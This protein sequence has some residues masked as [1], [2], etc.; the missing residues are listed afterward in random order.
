MGLKTDY[1]SRWANASRLLLF[2]SYGRNSLLTTTWLLIGELVW[3]LYNCWLHSELRDI[4]R[5][6]LIYN[7]ESRGSCH[8]SLRWFNVSPLSYTWILWRWGGFSPHLP[9]FFHWSHFLMIFERL[10]SGAPALWTM[11]PQPHKKQGAVWRC[12][13]AVEYISHP[14]WKSETLTFK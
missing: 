8:H 2:K 1:C 5:D 3:L 4:Y 10:Q 9:T 14:G 13:T 12:R 11:F 7:P 6:E